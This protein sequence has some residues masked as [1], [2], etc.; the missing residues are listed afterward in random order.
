MCENHGFLRAL[1][2][3]QPSEGLDENGHYSLMGSR[4]N[5]P[6]VGG[7]SRVDYLSVHMNQS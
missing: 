1:H 5:E 7:E 6:F 2:D 4:N 3:L